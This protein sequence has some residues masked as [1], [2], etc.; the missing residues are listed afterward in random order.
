MTEQSA[1]AEIRGIDI[2][3]LVEGFA[4]E[5]IVLKNY[6]RVQKASAREI[7]WYSKYVTSTGGSGKTGGVLTGPTTTDITAS[8]IANTSSKSL[9]V[10]IEPSYTRTTSYIKKYFATSPLIMIEDLKDCDPDVWADMIKDAVRAVNY[11]IDARILTVLDAAG[12]GTAA[13]TGSGWNVDADADPIL[14]FLAA[15]ESIKSYGYSTDNL[16]AYMNQAEE[17]WLLRWLINVKGSSIPQ[18]A[19]DKTGSGRL[20][21][22]LGIKIVSNAFRP[23][24][25]V[26]IF[27]PDKAVIWKE[28]M[29]TQSAVIDDAGIGKKVRVWAEGEAIRPNPYAVFKITDTIA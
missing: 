1:M 8:L 12:C 26:T 7:R 4:D 11:Q 24:D 25:T 22:I 13:A 15:K 23:T 21:E 5:G 2:Q 27:V 19:S 6:C 9:P 14:D 10:V 17:K 18:F 28:F 29:P 3:K 16:V 20:M